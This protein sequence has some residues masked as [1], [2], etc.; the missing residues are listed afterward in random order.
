MK[1][2]LVLAALAALVA[3]S[4]SALTIVNSKHDL[5][6]NN[7]AGEICIYCHTPHSADMGVTLAPLWNRDTTNVNADAD[8]YNSTTLNYTTT[9]ASV[10][11]TDAPL[12]LSCH[13]GGVAAALVNPPNAAGFVNNAVTFT[14]NAVILDATNLMKND[15]PIG[16][17]IPAAVDDAGIF[18]AAT[19]NTNLPG[20]LRGTNNTVWCSSC[21][22]VHD[23]A[24]APFLVK[25]NG[26]SAL[27]LACHNK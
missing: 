17:N 1:K 3:S 21:H 12:C 27:C 7:N 2:V 5:K 22:D 11:Q 18:A 4:A 16:I 24:N 25:A 10:N 14:G 19:I 23:N 6:A 9:A 15:H 26:G 8:L 13:D 20:A